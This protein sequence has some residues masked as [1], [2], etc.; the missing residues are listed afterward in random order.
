MVSTTIVAYTAI[1]SGDVAKR[2]P[3]LS[4]CDVSAKVPFLSKPMSETSCPDV[5]KL[6]LSR[7]SQGARTFYDEQ[8]EIVRPG[9][10]FVVYWDGVGSVEGSYQ[11]SDWVNYA[12]A[13]KSLELFAAC[14]EDCPEKVSKKCPCVSV[15]EKATLNSCG[16]I[17]TYDETTCEPVAGTA[18]LLHGNLHA[19]CYCY[20]IAVKNVDAFGYARG[21]EESFDS[22]QDLCTEVLSNLL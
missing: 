15:H 7:P 21:M 9:S 19:V 13:D 3:A 4:L 5:I 10:K 1:L 2:L 12:N 16:K 6:E 22:D 18:T 8:C 14:S 11:A 20:R 17:E